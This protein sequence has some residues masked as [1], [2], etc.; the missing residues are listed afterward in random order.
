VTARH[1]GPNDRP[2]APREA[3]PWPPHS[4]RA[5]LSLYR[6]PRPRN[7]FSAPPRAR[8]IGLLTH[9]PDH[10]HSTGRP[11]AAQFRRPDTQRS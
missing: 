10:V 8:A 7:W 5:S 2:T 4:E 11:A 6:P 9:P 1:G 3:A